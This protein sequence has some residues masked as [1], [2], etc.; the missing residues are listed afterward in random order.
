MNSININ[1]KRIIGSI[2]CLTKKQIDKHIKQIKKLKLDYKIIIDINNEYTII[3][4]KNNKQAKKALSIYLKYE[5][6]G[7]ELDS[8]SLKQHRFLGECFGYDEDEIGW[9][10]EDIKDEYQL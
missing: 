3:Y 1:Q 5:K 4:Y 2:E 10:I 9:F 6:S 8:I 7:G